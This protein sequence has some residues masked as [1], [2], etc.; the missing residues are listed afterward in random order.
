MVR[1]FNFLARV[2]LLGEAIVWVVEDGESFSTFGSVSSF[3]REVDA[4]VVV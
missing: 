4:I 1:A 3:E 2:A